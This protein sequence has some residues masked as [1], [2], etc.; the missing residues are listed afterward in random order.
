MTADDTTAARDDA[1]RAERDDA[2]GRREL[3]RTGTR[4]LAS[5]IAE[6]VTPGRRAGAAAVLLV[7]AVA[8]ALP[9]RALL[10][11][12]D[13][14]VGDETALAAVLGL[15]VG[16]GAAAIVLTMWMTRASGRLPSAA[17]DHP[18]WRDAALLDRAVDPAG[19]VTLAPGTAER[20]AVEARRAIAS[21]AIGVPAASLLVLAILAVIP[22]WIL[23]GETSVQMLL[24]PVYLFLGLSGLWTAARTAG[25]MARLRDAADAELALPESERTQAPPVVPPHGS[26]LP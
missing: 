21:A 13:D 24:T 3:L 6:V 11:H 10:L 25:R 22:A 1:P 26:R 8:A 23:Q 19:R 12:A 9:L 17:G 16:A 14:S 15:A 5:W 7:T 20:V 2:P 18:R 4:A